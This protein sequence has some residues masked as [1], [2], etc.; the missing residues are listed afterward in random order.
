M[1]KTKAIQSEN[2][3]TI[4]QLNLLLKSKRHQLGVGDDPSDFPEGREGDNSSGKT[5][6]PLMG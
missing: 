6:P 3:P 5:G 1:P 4:E 2:S